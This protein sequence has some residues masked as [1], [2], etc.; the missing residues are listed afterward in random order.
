VP[1]IAARVIIVAR[2][3]TLRHPLVL[4]KYPYPNCRGNGFGPSEQHEHSD[5]VV[6]IKD[7]GQYCDVPS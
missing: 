3:L 7:G 5:C 1:K 2:V 4:L 6:D